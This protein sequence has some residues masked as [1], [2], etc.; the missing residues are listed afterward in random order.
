MVIMSLHINKI[1]FHKSENLEK[2]ILRSQNLA[3][4]L[5]ENCCFLKFF[6]GF[7]YIALE[8]IVFEN[9]EK[10]TCKLHYQTLITLVVTQ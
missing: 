3:K 9:L 6:H 7:S 8:E 1:N 4:I 5:T 2:K 10:N